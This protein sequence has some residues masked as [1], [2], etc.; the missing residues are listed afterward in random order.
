MKAREQNLTD[1]WQRLFIEKEK[2]YEYR[3][4]E[5]RQSADEARGR[6][7]AVHERE[8]KLGRAA[9]DASTQVRAALHRYDD[10]TLISPRIEL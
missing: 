10:D 8:L 3:S 5:K 9:H 6:K 7:V 4:A 2:W 1:G